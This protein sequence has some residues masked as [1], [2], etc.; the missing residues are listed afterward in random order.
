[1]LATEDR[2][3]KEKLSKIER[4]YRAKEAA[5]NEAATRLGVPIDIRATE[6]ISQLQRLI[7]DA[8][9]QVARAREDLNRHRGWRCADNKAD[10]FRR[11][12]EMINRHCN[13]NRNQRFGIAAEV[14]HAPPNDSFLQKVVT[15]ACCA[16]TSANLIRLTPL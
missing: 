16:I 6:K 7:S 15:G 4:E 9:G 12:S 13:A 14:V 10:Y 2:I 8:E 11:L 3:L 1:M 5:F